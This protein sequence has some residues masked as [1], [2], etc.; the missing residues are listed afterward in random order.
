MPNHLDTIGTL[1]PLSPKQTQTWQL[2]PDCVQFLQRYGYGDFCGLLIFSEP[3]PDFMANNFADDMDLWQWH[4][5]SANAALAGTQFAQSIDGDII[6]AIAHAPAPIVLLPRHNNQPIVFSQLN[7]LFDY[8]V[9]RYALSPIY[10]DSHHQAAWHSLEIPA[11][12]QGNRRRQQTMQ[13]LQTAFLARYAPDAQLASEAQLQ[14]ALHAIGGWVRFDH[15]Y[16]SA[17]VI[18]YQQPYA[19]QATAIA[20][21]LEH[22]IEAA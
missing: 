14:Y 22:S 20:Q 9:Q 3:D 8:Y 13:A 1:A 2:P 10:F 12:I 5:I 18:K 11:R 7:Q 4:A 15:V 17:V 21:M 19:A 6:L 16:A